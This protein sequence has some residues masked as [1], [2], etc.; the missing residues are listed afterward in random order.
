MKTSF[1][2]VHLFVLNSSSS[3]LLSAPSSPA[4]LPSRKLPR[5]RRLKHA[6]AFWAVVSEL[7]VT[8]LVW[9]LVSSVLV[10]EV[11]ASEQLVL[12]VLVSEVQALE[13]LVLEVLLLEVLV[14]EVQAL[15][16]LVLEVLLLEVLVS[17]VQ[18]LVP[19]VLEVLLL[20][21]LVSE[22]QASVLLVLEVQE[23]E[24]QDSAATEELASPARWWLAPVSLEPVVSDTE[25]ELVS[26]V[27]DTVVL[28]MAVVSVV[29]D[30]VVL[31]MAAV[32]ATAEESGPA[33]AFRLVAT[34]MA[35]PVTVRD[36]LASAVVLP[37][38]T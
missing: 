2:R 4:E 5:R 31:A 26:V 30:T 16:P 11:Q 25:A 1:K 9:D 28:A 21:V 38:R 6:E 18:A 27:L 32:S 23:S 36:P 14:S 22:V 10:S 37:R 15:V 13:P 8:G 7:E 35:L 34:R 24:Q 12:E 33:T 19:L 20:E 3:P 17:E 29:L